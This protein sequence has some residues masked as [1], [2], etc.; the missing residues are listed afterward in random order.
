MPSPCSRGPCVYEH[1]HC[2]GGDALARRLRFRWKGILAFFGG[3][4]VLLTTSWGLVGFA[5][6]IFGVLYMFGSF[7]HT[8]VGYLGGV[9]IIGQLVNNSVVRGL[10]NLV[11]GGKRKQSMV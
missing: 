4:L 5:L 3:F 7:M 8:A 6:E 2:L 1:T 11:S 9:P 10:L